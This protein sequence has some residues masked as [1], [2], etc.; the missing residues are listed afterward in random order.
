MR[1]QS[2]GEI[3]IHIGEKLFGIYWK[4]QL[5]AI[6]KTFLYNFKPKSNSISV[7]TKH[8]FEGFIDDLYS[9]LKDIVKDKN[10][11]LAFY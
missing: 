8:R 5:T 10:T 1:A 3:P 11:L 9:G 4:T 2:K 6:L 7:Q